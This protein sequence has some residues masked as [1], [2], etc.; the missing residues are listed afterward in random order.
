MYKATLLPGD[1]IGPEV[2][3]A[4]VR[5]IEATGI[6][7]DWDL[8]NIGQAALLK[9]GDLLPAAAL[10]SIRRSKACLKGPTT[11]PIGTGFR[12]VNVALRKELGLYAN[13]RPA[14]HFPGVASAFPGTDII[15]IR[16]NTE[17]LYTG[18]EY[19]AGTPKARRIAKMAGTSPRAAV[20]LKLITAAATRRIADYAFRYAEEHGR[21]KVTA[22]HK[23]N[24]LKATD[25][26]FIRTA[27]AVAKKHPPVTYEEVIVDNLCAQLVK[28]PAEFDILLCPNLYGDIISDLCAGLIGG[29]G[30]VPSA[31][32]G[33]RAAVFEPVHG[34]APKYAGQNVANPTATILSGALLLRHLGERQAAQRL[35]DA[36]ALVI[37]DGTR[38]TKDIAPPGTPPV[39]TSQ[40]ADA[41]I[42]RLKR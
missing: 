5:C 40:M 2:V 23:A 7:V 34:S 33:S 38:V 35:E 32:I 12:S 28:R 13:L 11:T 29:L 3:Q 27:A 30:L 19:D 22:V 42:Q 16:E 15:V 6:Q 14:R 8:H 20:S 41:I 24:I 21:K 39:G 26:L 1:G 36:V 10:R 18:I 37:A 4:A 9:T 17:D 31:N 25:G